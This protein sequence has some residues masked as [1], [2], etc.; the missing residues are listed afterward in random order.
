MKHGKNGLLNNLNQAE[1]FNYM[2]LQWNQDRTDFKLLC[3]CLHIM[4]KK[5]IDYS[6]LKVY[7]NKCNKFLFG[8]GYVTLPREKRNNMIGKEKYGKQN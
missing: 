4:S 3:D 7:C 6:Q 1:H 8:I 2:H 5:D